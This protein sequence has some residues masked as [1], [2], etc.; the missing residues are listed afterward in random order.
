MTF[1][2]TETRKPDYPCDICHMDVQ[3]GEKVHV[4]DGGL[5]VEHADCARGWFRSNFGREGLS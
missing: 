3:A 1:T 4:T 2:A 5:T